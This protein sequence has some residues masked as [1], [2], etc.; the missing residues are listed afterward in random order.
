MASSWAFKTTAS[1]IKPTREALLDYCAYILLVIAIIGTTRIIIGRSELQQLCPRKTFIQS[2]TSQPL[3]HEFNKTGDIVLT[4]PNLDKETRQFVL[5]SNLKVHLVK[6]L[7]VAEGEDDISVHKQKQDFNSSVLYF[8]LKHYQAYLPYF[9][10]AESAVLLLIGIL[11]VKMPS[12]QLL[13]KE[14][15]SILHECRQSTWYVSVADVLQSESTIPVTQS[16]FTLMKSDAVNM[17]M[18]LLL[19]TLFRPNSAY[20]NKSQARR[21][22]ERVQKFCIENENSVVLLDSYISKSIVQLIAWMLF[23]FI[24]MVLFVKFEFYSTCGW[25]E[26]CEHDTFLR[27]IWYMAQLL[28]LVYGIFNCSA[29]KWINDKAVYINRPRRNF[30]CCE[31][32]NDDSSSKKRKFVKCRPFKVGQDQT[33]VHNDLALLLHLASSSNH[34][35]ITYFTIFLFDQWKEKFSQP[36]EDVHIESPVKQKLVKQFPARKSNS[37]SH[38][39]LTKSSSYGK[40]SFFIESPQDEATDSPSSSS[41]TSGDVSDRISST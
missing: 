5:Q 25:S 22:Y 21:L 16:L 23:F 18:I 1:L 8:C 37:S 13:I 14:F 2:N 24:N 27:I 20:L 41:K 6:D 34:K 7:K 29:L 39:L 17:E 4:K 38:P 12:V 30:L 26:V 33:V 32:D 35:T 31:D 28:V 11:W 15:A 10:L 40:V 3:T 36:V 9:L 19:E